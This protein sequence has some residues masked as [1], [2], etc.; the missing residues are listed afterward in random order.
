VRLQELKE[1]VANQ[2]VD[3]ETLVGLLELTIE[4]ILERHP[5][6]LLDNQHKFGVASADDS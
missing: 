3:V 2:V 1:L 5:D 4:D 6:A